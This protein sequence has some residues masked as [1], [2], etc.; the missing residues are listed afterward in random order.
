[1][2]SNLKVCQTGRYDGFRAT[3]DGYKLHGKD[4]NCSLFSYNTSFDQFYA[5]MIFS[6][7]KIT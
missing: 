2:N 6:N 3:F 5:V 7:L 1:M 4:G